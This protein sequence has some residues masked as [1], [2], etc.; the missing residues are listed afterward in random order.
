MIDFA[1]FQNNIRLGSFMIAND[2][3]DN[4]SNQTNV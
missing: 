3:I 4:I 1:L 2:T